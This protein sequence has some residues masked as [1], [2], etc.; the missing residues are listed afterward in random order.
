MRQ[1]P[2][3]LGAPSGFERRRQSGRFPDRG[4]DRRSGRSRRDE[5]ATGRPRPRREHASSPT[6]FDG[7][8][9]WAGST[10]PKKRAI[11]MAPRLRPMKHG[12]AE[13]AGCPRRRFKITAPPPTNSST[14]WPQTIFLWLRSGSPTSTAP[15][16]RRKR[17]GPAT[18][19]RC[20]ITPSVFA[21]SFFLPKRAAGACRAWP[22]GSW[23]HVS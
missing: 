16:R 12:C 14:G 5:G 1:R 18:E 8:A 20:T 21:R 7:C 13:N 9:F 22:R 2:I 15:L 19:E 17:S 6:R 11:P 10:K 23:L 4:R 3:E